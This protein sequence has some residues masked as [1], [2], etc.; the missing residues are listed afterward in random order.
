M[1]ALGVSRRWVASG[2]AGV[3][4][5]LTAVP[6]V[7]QSVVSVGTEVGEVSEE[8]VGE[9]LVPEHPRPP[10]LGQHGVVGPV[11]TDTLVPPKR[12]LAVGSGGVAASPL[13]PTRVLPLQVRQ[14]QEDGA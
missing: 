13:L 12:P 7:H 11:V 4:L 6:E 2:R 10:G 3:H 9:L 5:L 14:L 1:E 8:A